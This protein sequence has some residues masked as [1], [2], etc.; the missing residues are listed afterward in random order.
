MLN[1]IICKYL[2]L[3]LYSQ[4]LGR[5]RASSRTLKDASSA[6]S[7]IWEDLNLLVL[8]MEQQ[9]T[10]CAWVGLGFHY[11]LCAL[12]DGPGDSLLFQDTRVLGVHWKDPH[13]P[14]ISMAQRARCL[15]GLQL[16]VAPKRSLFKPEVGSYAC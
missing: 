11:V 8:L 15:W 7:E 14:C 5:I 6:H 4:V 16:T 9:Q 12:A 10:T 3:A 1:L 2:H 13:H